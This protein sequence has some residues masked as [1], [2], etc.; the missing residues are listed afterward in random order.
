MAGQFITSVDGRWFQRADGII[1]R[2]D[3]PSHITRMLAEGWHEVDGPHASTPVTSDDDDEL[4]SVAE[5]LEEVQA[6]NAA[7]RAAF[8]RTPPAT[9]AALKPIRKTSEK[10]RRA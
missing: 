3:D 8:S 9:G 1:F 2:M 4:P 5:T 6:R 10:G 7:A